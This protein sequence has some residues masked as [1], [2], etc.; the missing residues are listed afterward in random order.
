MHATESRFEMTNLIQRQFVI[1]VSADENLIVGIED[2]SDILLHH[3][4]DHGILTPKGHQYGDGLLRLRQE[5][6]SRRP[7]LPGA[8]AQ[9]RDACDKIDEQVI[10]AAEKNPDGDRP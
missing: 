5:C 3:A 6:P 7:I 4:G 9:R 8:A 10:E 2:G 1:G